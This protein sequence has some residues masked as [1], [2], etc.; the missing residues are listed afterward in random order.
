MPLIICLCNELSQGWVPGIVAS[1]AKMLERW[2]A[3]GDGKEKFELEVCK[4]LHTLTADVISLT[5]FG[6]SFEEGKRIFEL[7]EQLVYLSSLAVK[8]LYIPGFR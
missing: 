3:A 6:S 5:A 4:E 2:E 1:T 7:Q 8:S